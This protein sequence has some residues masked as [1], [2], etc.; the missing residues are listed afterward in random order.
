MNAPLL[1]TKLVH[2]DDVRSFQIRPVLPAGWEAAE[3]ENHR[4]VYQ[5]HYA[6]WHRLELTLVRFRRE[7]ADL[8]SQGWLEA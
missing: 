4:V 7:I 5:R 1:A 2:A 6:D 8:R 3:Y